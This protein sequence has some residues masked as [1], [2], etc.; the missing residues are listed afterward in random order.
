VA[1]RHSS[2]R[3][4][5]RIAAPL[6]IMAGL[7]VLI[8]TAWFTF[9]FL[10][11]QLGREGCTNPV[12]V[13]VAAEPAIAPAL[14]EIAAQTDKERNLDS[15]QECYELQ[16]VSQESSAVAD[17]LTGFAPGAQP[18][19]WVPDS[20]FWL[21]RARAGGAIDLPEAG[22][23]LA[24]SP[25]VLGVAE[26]AA[27]R[28]GWPDR[29]LG[30]QDVLGSQGLQI[31]LPDPARNPVG[32]SA[33]FGIRAVTSAG[34]EPA[35]AQVAALRR[36]EPN[37]ATRPAE[38]FKQLP[39][40]YD[41][42]AVAT[43]VAAFP[44][45]EQAVL[46]HN[47]TEP[48]RRLVAVYVLPPVP[49]LDYPYVVLSTASD[50]ERRGAERLL[51]ALLDRESQRTL[52]ARGLRSPRGEA[53]A[54]FPGSEADRPAAVDPV[55][56]PDQDA[57]D[58]VQR[59][60]TGVNLSARILTVIDV[61]GSMRARVPGTDLTRV[62][63]T[64]EAAKQG[65][66]LFKDTTDLGLWAFSSRLD[67]DR[68]YRELAPISPLATERA[69]LIALADEVVGLVGGATN[70]YDT[71]LAGYQTVAQGWDPARL[72]VLIVLTDG[73]DDD[74]SSITREQLVAELTALQDPKRPT[75]IIFVGLGPDVDAAE[76]DQI[77]SVTGGRAFTT[78]DPAGIGNVIAAALAELTCIPPDCTPR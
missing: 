55:P 68:P 27:R 13:E 78:P 20:T 6:P 18:D 4:A 40:A 24:S 56:L 21:R 67:G 71:V 52:Q 45:S 48:S 38:L 70:L 47:N 35:A 76:L 51:E 3:S 22:A 72:N 1:G 8:I 66:G 69:R 12:T 34:P 15:P 31:G 10:S 75:R 64:A 60:W 39:P 26:P 42:G 32:L 43:A 58:E 16:V 9:Q 65:L 53:G 5:P 74:V 30:W 28:L 44:A 23:S 62:Q 11:T 19:V 77:A 50:V 33:L 25:L 73:R 61:S 46:R 17:R 14:A 2:G 57:T 54:D 36:L 7:L 59:V 49:A 29:E 37:V 63:I 41:P